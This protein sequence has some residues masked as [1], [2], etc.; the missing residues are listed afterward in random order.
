MTTKHRN[1]SD[2]QPTVLTAEEVQ[3]AVSNAVDIAK[4]RGFGV[5]YPVIVTGAIV[6][7]HVAENIDLW[8][9]PKPG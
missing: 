2:K 1:P 4:D 6:A 7:G 8:T 3:T 5:L 9:P